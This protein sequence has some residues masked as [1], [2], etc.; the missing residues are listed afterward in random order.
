MYFIFNVFH[1]SE[2]KCIYEALTFMS[3]NEPHNNFKF[4]QI[5][6][7]NAAISSL[8]ISEHIF[9][10]ITEW[11]SLMHLPK[12]AFILGLNLILFFVIVCITLTMAFVIP[13]FTP[14]PVLFNFPMKLQL[15]TDEEPIFLK[16]TDVQMPFSLP[17]YQ[18]L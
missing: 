18:T 15:V 7:S 1:A 6:V 2:R 5:W 12:M 4:G 14:V 11:K 9:R 13:V 16:D 17:S 8:Y 3:G 10:L